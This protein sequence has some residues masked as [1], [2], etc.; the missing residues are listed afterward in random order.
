MG[1]DQGV[2]HEGDDRHRPY[3]ARVIALTTC[4]ADAK[5]TSPSSFFFPSRMT[6]VVPTSITVAHGLIQSERC[7]DC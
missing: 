4:E 2:V 3:A 1:R 7:N 5:S 6:R